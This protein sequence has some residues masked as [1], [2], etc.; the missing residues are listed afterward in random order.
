LTKNLFVVPALALGLSL[1]ASA[2][3]VPN[4]VGIIHIQNAMLGTKDGQKAL[5]DLQTRFKP[6]KDELDKLQNDIALSQEQLNKGSA[7]MNEDRR[8]QLVRDIDSKKKTLQRQ[9]EDAQAEVEQAESKIMQELFGKLGAVLNKYAA[10]HGYSLILDVSSQQTP[11]MYA[12]NGIDITS[13]VVNLYNATAPGAAA[14]AAP[15]T[16]APR[17]TTPSTAA[18]RTAPPAPAPA[19][20]K[21]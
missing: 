18:P 2:Q 4:K 15:A 12:A 11:V 5:G 13:D 1:A 6:K 16:A 7:T 17:P 19:P 14:P 21:K 20:K 8:N 3:G 10:D 9:T